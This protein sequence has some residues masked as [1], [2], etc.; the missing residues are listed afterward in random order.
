LIQQAEISKISPVRPYDHSILESFVDSKKDKPSK[1]N[2][3]SH[4]GNSQDTRVHIEAGTE[5]APFLGDARNL[6]DMVNVQPR[7]EL[8]SFT[9]ILAERLLPWLADHW[10]WL[11]RRKVR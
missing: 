9:R 6:K 4:S 8:D 1:K 2:G 11:A 3:S 10:K 5:N 7:P